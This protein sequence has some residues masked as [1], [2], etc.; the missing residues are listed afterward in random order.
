M[1]HLLIAL[2]L[3]PRSR[4][5]QLLL[6]SNVDR[7]GVLHATRQARAAQRGSR[8]WTPSLDVLRAFGLVDGGSRLL[9]PAAAFLRWRTVKEMD[10]G[11][12]MFVL[13]CEADRQAVRLG[14]DRVSPAHLLAA[15]AAV[16]DQLQSR[17][18]RLR[19]DLAPHSQGGRILREQNVGYPRLLPEVA[20][21]TLNGFKLADQPPQSR[22]PGPP[23]TAT[24]STALDQAS[25]TCRRAG[26]EHLLQALLDGDYPDLRQV[27]DSLGV[28]PLPIRSAVEEQLPHYEPHQ[29]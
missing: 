15:I 24:S 1:T 23:W 7:N 11:P 18:A 9:R 29:P 2:L 22:R 26:S 21:L 16:D 6:L 4:A 3:D 17:G 19:D 25:R 14:H 27:L 8:P 12:E 28:D 13:R 20:Q 10:S 5:S